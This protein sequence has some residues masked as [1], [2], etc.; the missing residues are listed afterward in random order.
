MQNLRCK[1]LSDGRAAEVLRVV[2]ATLAP[3]SDAWKGIPEDIAGRIAPENL[4]VFHDGEESAENPSKLMKFSFFREELT[5]REA[6]KFAAYAILTFANSDLDFFIGKGCLQA[7]INVLDRIYADI[8]MACMSCICEENRGEILKM[9]NCGEEVTDGDKSGTV[10]L[11]AFQK[12]IVSK[13]KDG[14]AFAITGDCVSVDPVV[15]T[16]I[17]IF[18]SSFAS[19][20]CTEVSKDDAVKSIEN[21]MFTAIGVSANF[22][23]N[24]DIAQACDR[25]LTYLHSAGKVIPRYALA[26]D[27]PGGSSFFGFIPG[28]GRP[29]FLRTDE[30]RAE[31]AP[32]M[33]LLL[34]RN[35]HNC[36][37][38][39]GDGP[40]GDI[41][42]GSV[43]FSTLHV[44]RLMGYFY[45]AHSSLGGDGS[46]IFAKYTDPDN[47]KHGIIRDEISHYAL[48]FKDGTEFFM[49]VFIGLALGKTFSDDV[50]AI[51]RELN[52]VELDF[53][54]PKP[55]E[56][57]KLEDSDEPSSSEGPS[58]SDEP[59]GLDEPSES[60]DPSS[61]EEP[62]E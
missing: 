3:D 36:D 25:V 39:S 40:I 59:S 60:D 2:D 28:L 56:S 53:P 48:L 50:M 41:G 27:M 11:E 23:D 8:L 20:I 54:L 1:L 32:H 10:T 21:K 51:Y 30:L 47:E 31:Y 34:N 18:C 45:H 22:A 38:R 42:D 33:P 19:S 17:E 52:G 26:V 12:F 24:I 62:D 44:L 43:T 57:E 14:S 13:F 46:A 55:P 61:S 4:I 16:F 49:R 37:M 58:S 29:F 5:L 9:L 35:A 7:L 15:K 6:K